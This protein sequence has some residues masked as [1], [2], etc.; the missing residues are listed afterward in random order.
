MAAPRPTDP[1]DLRNALEDSHYLLAYFSRSKVDMPEHKRGEFNEKVKIVSSLR[2]D[3]VPSAPSDKIAEFW[4]AFIYLSDRAVPATIESIR[5]YFRYKDQRWFRP[6][7]MVTTIA[8]FITIVLSLLSYIG[9]RA[10]LHYDDD[11]AH[12]SQ[13]QM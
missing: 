7:T 4:E 12:W 6:F 13:M 9:S 5:Y 1:A 10:I 2:S 3:D 8:L 11:Y